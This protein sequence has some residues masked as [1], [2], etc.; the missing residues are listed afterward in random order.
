MLQPARL[1]VL[2]TIELFMT[3]L[4]HWERHGPL[5]WKR[6]MKGNGKI[7]KEE[8]KECQCVVVS[9]V[10]ILFCELSDVLEPLFIWE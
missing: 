6:L 10:G 5:V 3:A 4:P 7:K 9:C 1:T 2:T 8:N